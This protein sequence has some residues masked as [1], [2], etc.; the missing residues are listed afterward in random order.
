M[1]PGHERCYA[2]CWETGGRFCS[3]R[4]QE[5]GAVCREGNWAE[6]AAAGGAGWQ[7]PAGRRASAGQR[8]AGRSP[9]VAGARGREERGARQPLCTAAGDGEARARRLP[10]PGRAPRPLPDNLPAGKEL[11]VPGPREPGAPPSS[12]TALP[13]RSRESPEISRYRPAGISRA[14]VR[15]SQHGGVGEANHYFGTLNVW[16]VLVLGGRGQTG[17]EASLPRPGFLL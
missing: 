1:T 5:S 11:L 7:R 15:W 17:G 12:A 3:H 9:Q 6:G 14:G 10:A 2:F 8:P 13:T 4:R 16:F